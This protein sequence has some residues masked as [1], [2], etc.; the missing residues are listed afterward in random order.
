MSVTTEGIGVFCA[1]TR[2]SNYQAVAELV[3]AGRPAVLINP[4]QVRDFARAIGQ[5]AK[6]DTLDVSILARL[7]EWIRLRL[8]EWLDDQNAGI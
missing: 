1:C 7:G 6:A 4:R 3:A 8:R 2:S 5:L